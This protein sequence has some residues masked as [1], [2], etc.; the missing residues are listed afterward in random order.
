MTSEPRLT[1]ITRPGCHLC[2]AALEVVEAV[3][4]E[5]AGIQ[6]AGHRVAWRGQHAVAGQGHLQQG[7]NVVALQRQRR[8]QQRL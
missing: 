7:V 3:R 5:L 6:R 1:L 4:D 8:R 2:E